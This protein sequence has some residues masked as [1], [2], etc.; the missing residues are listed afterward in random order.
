LKNKQIDNGKEEYILTTL[1][2]LSPSNAPK[3]IRANVEKLEIVQFIF[4]I[5]QPLLKQLQLNHNAIRHF[6]EIVQNTESGHI[7]RKEEIDR[8][9]NLATFC[10][11]QRCI[12]KIGWFAP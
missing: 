8:Y 6:G 10:A 9:F 2:K 7:V 11:Y 4:E 1:H 3:Q 5:V 12:L